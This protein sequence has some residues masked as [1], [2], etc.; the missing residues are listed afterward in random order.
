[1]NQFLFVYGTLMQGQSLEGYLA[2]LSSRPARTQGQLFRLPAGYPALAESNKDDWVHGELVSLPS[3]SR[4]TVLDMVEGVNK[5]LFFRKKIP[6]QLTNQKL[7]AWAY[8]MSLRKIESLGG[9]PIHS[10]DWCKVSYASPQ[11]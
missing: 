4:L 6:V 3:M 5:G 1:M 7:H 2:G 11:Q 8:V 9:Q 10:G